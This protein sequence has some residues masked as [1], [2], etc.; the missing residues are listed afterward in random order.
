MLG[1]SMAAHRRGTG[2]PG[3]HP[4]AAG[5]PGCSCTWGTSGPRA[6]WSGP[7]PASA[8][9]H[10]Q[11]PGRCCNLGESTGLSAQ[12]DGT[13][14]LG[15]ATPAG[16]VP[17]W[18]HSVG[19]EGAGKGADTSVR[20]EAP[21]LVSVV[22]AGGGTPELAVLPALAGAGAV[23]LPQEGEGEDARVPLGVAADHRCVCSAVSVGLALAP[24][25]ASRTPGQPKTPRAPTPCTVAG[26]RPPRAPHPHS[27]LGWGRSHTS[28]LGRS[29]RWWH[30]SGSRQSARLWCRHRRRCPQR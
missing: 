29:W 11:P 6:R 18:R 16:S 9:T 7:A 24:G 28:Y 21:L 5:S 23:G 2:C 27:H 22:V 3:H 19:P 8:R 25:H 4:G 20:A 10:G 14:Q 30:T 13:H 15:T 26:D 1:H 17:V 12:W